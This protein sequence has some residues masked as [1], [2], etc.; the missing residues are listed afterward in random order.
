MICLLELNALTL[1][2]VDTYMHVPIKLAQFYFGLAIK[3][4][5]TNTGVAKIPV[6]VHYNI[7]L[8]F[9]KTAESPIL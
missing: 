4:G 8:V 6:G 3:S 7:H 5:S 9:G 1:L 2:W